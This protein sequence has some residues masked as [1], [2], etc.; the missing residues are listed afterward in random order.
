[1]VQASEEPEAEITLLE[2][3]R[4]LKGYHIIVGLAFLVSL[5]AFPGANSL[6]QWV[7]VTS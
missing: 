6:R 2:L 5:A 4:K 7:L 3:S 1:M